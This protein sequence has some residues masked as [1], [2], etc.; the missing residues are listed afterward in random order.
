VAND[1]AISASVATIDHLKRAERVYRGI[2][3]PLPIREASMMDAAVEGSRASAL[4]RLLRAGYDPALTEHPEEHHAKAGILQRY[5]MQ[6]V[7][8]FESILQRGLVTRAS[9]PELRA[10]ITAASPFLQGKPAF[11][12]ERIVRTETMSAYNRGSWEATREADEDL[13]DV[14][15]ILVATFDDRTASDS[16]AVHGQIRRP[17]EAFESWFG[18]YQHPPNRPNDREVVITH[19]LCWPLPQYLTPV[20]D[21][22]LLARWTAEQPKTHRK[23]YKP[24]HM[25]PRPLLST[26]DRG[27]FGSDAASIEERRAR[28]GDRRGGVEPEDDGRGPPMGEDAA[29]ALA[30]QI[31]DAVV[32]AR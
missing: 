18:L 29:A 20:S 26:I 21:D 19:R 31:A 24:K 23:G 10:Q 32:A 9:V 7:K 13:G 11:W 30:K 1:A 12:A 22:V 15:K 4:R 6:T 8:E 25:P 14:F 27:K 5:G 28:K 2:S 3:Q 16:Y 17:E